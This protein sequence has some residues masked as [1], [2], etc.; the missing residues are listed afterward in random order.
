MILPLGRPIR[1]VWW[2]APSRQFRTALN[3]QDEPPVSTTAEQLRLQDD[4]FRS[5][6]NAM[7]G[8]ASVMKDELTLLRQTMQQAAGLTRRRAKINKL[9][10]LDARLWWGGLFLCEANAFG[11]CSFL[12]GRHVLTGYFTSKI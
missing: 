1:P 2:R 10:D 4:R 9:P 7:T 5:M 8:L 6:E 12:P 11:I 3:G